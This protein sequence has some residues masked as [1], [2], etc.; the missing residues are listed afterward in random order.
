M[1][2]EISH[3]VGTEHSNVKFQQG[4]FNHRFWTSIA[5]IL[6]RLGGKMGFTLYEWEFPYQIQSIIIIEI[7]RNTCFTCGGQMEDSTIQS[8]KWESP[9][10][11]YKKIPTKLRVC[12]QCG[13]S[14]T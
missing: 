3:K 6:E 5:N 10:G 7:T 11:G 2:F 14:H 8:I 9:D 12:T 4:N 13:H 1:Q